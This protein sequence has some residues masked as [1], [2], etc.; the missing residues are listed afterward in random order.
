MFW[1]LQ[2]SRVTAFTVSELLKENQQRGKITS[3]TQIGVNISTLIRWNVMKRPKTHRFIRLRLI[4]SSHSLI[5]ILEWLGLF[6]I[7]SVIFD[8]VS[9]AKIMRLKIAR[10]N[11]D[12]LVILIT[13]RV[14]SH[15]K[16]CPGW[17]Y[18][19]QTGLEKILMSQINFNLEW[20]RTRYENVFTLF[21]NVHIIR[22]GWILIA[23]TP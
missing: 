14:P 8:P 13:L 10:K 1:I 6:L 19:F 7:P 16:F 9:M 11:V 18:Q 22:P 4:N 2:N 15:M 12:T 3:L 20:K 17:N 23:V 21:N 5:N